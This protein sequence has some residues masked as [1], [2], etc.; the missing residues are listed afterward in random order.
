MKKETFQRRV[1]GTIKRFRMLSK[2]DKVLAAVSGGADSMV[3]AHVL[4]ALSDR[5][6][7]NAG[8]IH[9]NHGIRGLASEEDAIFVEEFAR[10]LDIPFHLVKVDVPRLAK[11][12]KAG[13]EESGRRARYRAMFK[14]ARETGYGRIATGHTSDDQAET[15]LMRLLRGAGTAGLQ[16]VLPVTGEGVIRPLL[17]VSREEVR[18]YCL[19]ARL[20]FRE[21]ASNLDPVFLR[22]RIRHQLIPLLER[23]YNPALRDILAATALLCGEDE[24]FLNRE[25][26]RLFEESARRLG[27][28][29]QI[30]VKALGRMPPALLSRVLREAIRE[31]RGDLDGITGRHLRSVISLLEGGSGRR[32][33]L[34]GGLSACREYGLLKFGRMREEFSKPEPIELSIPGRTVLSPWDLTVEASITGSMPELCRTGPLEACMDLDALR[35]PVTARRRAQGDRFIP[36]GMGGFKKVKDF[37]IDQKVPR[38]EREKIPVLADGEKIIWLVGFR[39][40]E[41]VRVSDKTRRILFLKASRGLMPEEMNRDARQDR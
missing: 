11:E 32:C 18:D 13:L 6:E 39:V 33:E 5:L 12:D 28:C 35:L 41:R 19:T 1:L 24:R 31:I 4:N 8:I 26:L 27:E 17:E 21:D 22:N 3:L 15:V 2:G 30:E 23:E 14:L 29:I 37:L 16:A 9:V 10:G 7:I 40:D 38:A 20:P 25:S 34:P 36:F